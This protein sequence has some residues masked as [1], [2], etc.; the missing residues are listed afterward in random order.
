M[1]DECLK[2]VEN[3]YCCFVILFGTACGSTQFTL[4]VNLYNDVIFSFQYLPSKEIHISEKAKYDPSSKIY[5]V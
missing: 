4:K 3:M 2:L 5:E 1:T